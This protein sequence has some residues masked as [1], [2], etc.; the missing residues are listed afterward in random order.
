MKGGL[1]GQRVGWGAFKV[2]YTTQKL[3]GIGSLVGRV[4]K[5]IKGSVHSIYVECKGNPWRII[6]GSERG[7]VHVVPK[8]AD[9][10]SNDDCNF[11]HFP[12]LQRFLDAKQKVEV[13][14]EVK[15]S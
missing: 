13:A 4:R 12:N 5:A 3:V 1:G 14:T 10:D 6:N 8:V 7:L 2:R 11:K 9:C 15:N